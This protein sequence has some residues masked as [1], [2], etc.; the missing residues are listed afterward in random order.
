MVFFVVVVLTCGHFGS[1][2]F[3]I[4]ICVIRWEL[5]NAGGRMRNDVLFTVDRHISIT[6]E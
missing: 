5:S 6:R 3:R 1:F 2:F 4:P